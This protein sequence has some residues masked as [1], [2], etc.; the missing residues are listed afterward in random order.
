MTEEEKGVAKSQWGHRQQRVRVLAI[1]LEKPENTVT[2]WEATFER[3]PKDLEFTLDAADL[4]RLQWQA[5]ARSRPGILK[6]LWESFE[7]NVALKSK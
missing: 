1:V 3:M 6:L 2:A 4:M 7:V 5:I